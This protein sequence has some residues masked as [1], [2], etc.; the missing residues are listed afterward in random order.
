MINHKAGTLWEVKSPKIGDLITD[1]LKVSEYVTDFKIT[2][3]Q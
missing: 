2:S 1:H 3:F